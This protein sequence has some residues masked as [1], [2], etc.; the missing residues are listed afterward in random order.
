M[1]E[2]LWVKEVSQFQDFLKRQYSKVQ[3]KPSRSLLFS[4]SLLVWPWN[5]FK[6]VWDVVPQKSLKMAD[7]TIVSFQ[8]LL[9]QTKLYYLNSKH[10]KTFVIDHFLPHRIC[11][12]HVKALSFTPLMIEKETFPKQELLSQHDMMFKEKVG[13]RVEV[14]SCILATPLRWK[15]LQVFFFFTSS[16]LTHYTKWC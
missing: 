7:I 2:N 13:E 10:L 4:V 14:T 6:L 8:G 1:L 3:N 11:F 15:V 16:G 9:H 5:P 12:F